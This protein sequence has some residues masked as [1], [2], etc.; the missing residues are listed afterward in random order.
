MLGEETIEER[1]YRLL[2]YGSVTTPN[3]HVKPLM[4]PVVPF[5]GADNNRLVE[6]IWPTE[7]SGYQGSLQ[8][9]DSSDHSV[10]SY[11]EH[12]VE[13]R[14]DLESNEREHEEYMGDRENIVSSEDRG[15]FDRMLMGYRDGNR[16]ES[17]K[18]GIETIT[19]NADALPSMFLNLRKDIIKP[20]S[21]CDSSL[22]ANETGNTRS[23]QERP[24]ASIPLANSF[25]Q[26]DLDLKQIASEE[27]E[28]SSV[29]S[30]TS[31]VTNSTPAIVKLKARKRLL[32][33]FLSEKSLSSTGELNED[34]YS[35]RE[36]IL[37]SSVETS[38]Y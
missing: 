24:V 1:A 2:L 30:S 3:I 13:E 35:I 22:T 14:L 29:F 11:R 36:A 25:F 17:E 16:K 33:R 4:I 28:V 6:H 23:I 10:S 19:S 27:T 26:L 8:R 12:S 20:Y 9:D 18:V 37:P 5:D 34:M 38:C 31:T 7:Y 15:Q 21:K 32:E